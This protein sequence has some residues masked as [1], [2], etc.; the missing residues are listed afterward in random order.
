M[1]SKTKRRQNKASR[2][3]TPATPRGHASNAMDTQSEISAQDSLLPVSPFETP[4]TS[5][6]S[7]SAS[8]LQQSFTV[9][10]IP[11]LEPTISV[12]DIVSTDIVEIADMF[13]TMK[14]AMLMMTS[15]FS[16]FEI[17]TQ[18]LASLSLDI[19]AAEQVR[20]SILKFV[21]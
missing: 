17:Q 19:K 6:S 12:N 11:P 4:P 13:A 15:A 21:I 2:P 10:Q 3:V 8:M 9:D 14:R 16:R 5:P 18:K 7:P 1:G 20:P